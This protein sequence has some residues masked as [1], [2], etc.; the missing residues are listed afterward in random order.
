MSDVTALW[1]AGPVGTQAFWI[2]LTF[3]VILLATEAFLGT[4][5]L[6][7]SAAAA[8]VVA[9]ICLT[10]APV[11]TAGQVIVF[12]VLSL[13]MTVLTRRFLKMGASHPDIN[14]QHIRLVGKQA[15]VLSGFDVTGGERTGR[16]MYDGVEWPAVLVDADTDFL[17]TQAK[18]LIERIYE[19]RLYVRMV[20][21]D[22]YA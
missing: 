11:A 6:L 20:T 22:T 8:G 17:A 3:G 16:V 13:V 10:G 14:D 2:W 19:G 4:Q 9:V 5:W 1:L 7:W 21:D 15:E 12:A 18:V